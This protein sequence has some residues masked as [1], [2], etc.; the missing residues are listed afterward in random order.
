MC[1]TKITMKRKNM[2]LVG[3]S[4]AFSCNGVRMLGQ[5]SINW[6]IRGLLSIPSNSLKHREN[7]AQAQ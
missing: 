4:K 7:I 2:E 3:K 1:I 5:A 6:E